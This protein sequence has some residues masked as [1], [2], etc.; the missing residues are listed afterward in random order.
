MKFFFFTFDGPFYQVRTA[1]IDNPIAESLGV[2]CSGLFRSGKIEG[3]TFPVFNRFSHFFLFRAVASR[4]RALRIPY[5]FDIDDVLWALPGFSSDSVRENGALWGKIDLLLKGASVITTTNELLSRE[6]QEKYPAAKVFVVPNAAPQ[7]QSVPGGVLIANTDSLKL[8]PDS[9]PWFRSLLHKLVDSGVPVTLMG[10]NQNFFSEPR[11]LRFSASPRLPYEEY[12]Q[13]LAHGE[14]RFGLIPVEEGHYGDCKSEIKAL[15]FL[16][17]GMDV[18]A[19]AIAPYTSLK[20][21]HPALPLT[22]VNNR[23]EE[24]RSVVERIAS[25]GADAERQRRA[26]LLALQGDQRSSQFAAWEE[27]YRYLSELVKDIDFESAHRS[28]RSFTL[29]IQRVQRVTLPARTVV[30]KIIA[31]FR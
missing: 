13:S 25:T 15:E 30:K 27:V 17:A 19:S 14:F 28:L 24:W 4:C 16:G 5:I 18:F 1:S 9:L 12:V 26:S 23:E 29:Q 31:R 22:I 2:R 3:G 21:R 11:D 10:E 6:L 20:A 7:T 8:S